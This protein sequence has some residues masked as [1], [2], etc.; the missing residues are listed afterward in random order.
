MESDHNAISVKHFTKQDLFIGSCIALWGAVATGFVAICMRYMNKG[1]H[2]TISPFW[3][4]CGCSVLGPIYHTFLISKSESY[5]E[6]VAT[7][8]DSYTIFLILVSSVASSFG[9][10]LTSR[11]F[12]MEKTSRVSFTGYL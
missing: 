2:Y 9:Q 3:Y 11:A 6:R 1:I 12:Q 4:S 10:I 8:Y 5:A 7:S